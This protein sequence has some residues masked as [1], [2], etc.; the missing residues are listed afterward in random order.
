MSCGRTYASPTRVTGPTKFMTNSFAGVSYSSRGGPTC[1]TRPRA[2]S[3][4]SSATSIA[5]S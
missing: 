1:S 4:T 5:S 3:T 2:I